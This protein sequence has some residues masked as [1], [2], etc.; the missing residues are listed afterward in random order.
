MNTGHL[1]ARDFLL[2]FASDYFALSWMMNSNQFKGM[3]FLLLF[4]LNSDAASVGAS[5]KLSTAHKGE[6]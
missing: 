4:L 3:R 2:C 1:D 6:F 5:I